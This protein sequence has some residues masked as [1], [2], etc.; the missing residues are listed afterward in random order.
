[1]TQEEIIE[2]YP[3]LEPED[4]EKCLHYA[5]NLSNKFAGKLPIE[6]TEKLEEHIK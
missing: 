1:M 5:A 3:Y 6:I 2:E 4:I